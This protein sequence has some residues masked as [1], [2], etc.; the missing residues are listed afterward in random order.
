MWRGVKFHFFSIGSSEHGVWRSSS[1]SRVWVS[2][3]FAFRL[4]LWTVCSPYPTLNLRRPSFSSRRCTDLKQSSAAYHICC[5]TSR[6][7]LSLEDTLLRTLLP[8]ITVVV[9]AKW[10]CHFMDTLIALTYLL[11]YLSGRLIGPNMPFRKFSSESIPLFGAIWMAPNCIWQTRQKPY[12]SC[13]VRTTRNVEYFAKS[14]KVSQGLSKWDR[15]V[16]RV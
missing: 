12:H 10:H 4:V 7:L 11:T 13:V 5:V 3:A 1:S 9:P 2:K 6:L 16:R 14:F 15:C 8:V